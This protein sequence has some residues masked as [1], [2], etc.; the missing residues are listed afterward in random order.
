MRDHEVVTPEDVE[1]LRDGFLEERHLPNG[2]SWE[3]VVI[4]VKKEIPELWQLLV[5]DHQQES[6]LPVG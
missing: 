3:D 4:M 1:L 5:L 6:V 2:L